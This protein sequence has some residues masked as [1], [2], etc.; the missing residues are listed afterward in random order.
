MS[1]HPYDLTINSDGI[2]VGSATADIT[3]GTGRFVNATGSFTTQEANNLQGTIT[4]DF[5]GTINY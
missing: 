3:G 4:T 1:A 2:A 5:D